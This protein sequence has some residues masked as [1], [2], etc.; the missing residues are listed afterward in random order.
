MAPSQGL[1]GKKWPKKSPDR[2]NYPQPQNTHSPALKVKISFL[3]L[4]D[5]GYEHHYNSKVTNFKVTPLK[6]E[7]KIKSITFGLN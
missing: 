3:L 6:K 2:I 7:K 1:W 4:D 5:S